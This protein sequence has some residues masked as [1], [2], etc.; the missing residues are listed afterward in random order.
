[1]EGLEQIHS[2]QA[3]ESLVKDTV[4]QENQYLEARAK[5][6]PEPKDKQEGLENG[7]R[8]HHKDINGEGG[9][10]GAVLTLFGN[11]PIPKQLFSSMQNPFRGREH[12]SIKAE[13]PV[14]EISLPNGLTATRVMPVPVDEG[15]RGPTLEE[16]FAPPYSLP[17]LHPPKA[18]KRSSTRD[19]TVTWEF[20]DSVQRNKKGGYTVQS[21]SVAD[22]LSYS[23]VESTGDTF[24]PLEKRMQRD[25]ALSGGNSPV[26]GPTKAAMDDALAKEEEALFRRAYSSFAPSCDN[27]KALVSEELKNMVW[28]QKSGNRRFSEVFAL[29]PALFDES[30]TSLDFPAVDQPDSENDDFSKVIEELDD[31]EN[32]PLDVELVRSKKDVEQ[33]LLEISELLETLASYQRIRNASLPPSTAASRTPI[34]PAP[35]LASQIGKPDDPAEDEMATYHKLRRELA[36]LLLQLPPYAVAKLNGD[37]FSELGVSKLITFAKQDTRGTM[38]E[39]Q[40]ARQARLAAMASASGIASLT[41][42]TSS[43]GQHYNTTAQR[44]PAIGQAA[45]TRYGQLSQFGSRTPIAPPQYQQR[46]SSA[47]QHY[48]TPAARAPGYGQPNHYNRPV[49]AQPSYGQYYQQRPPQQNLA[50]YGSYTPQYHQTPQAQQRPKYYSSQHPSQYQPRFQAGPN[51]AAYQNYAP[52]PP[53]TYN[54]AGS[55]SKPASYAPQMQQPPPM[56]QQHGYPPQPPVSGR[57]TPNNY[58][59]HQQ[60]PVNGYQRSPLPSAV[61]PRP[62]ST[63]PQP[64]PSTPSAA[65]PTP[66]MMQANGHP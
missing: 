57:V 16:A 19:A 26:Q 52:T 35:T 43:A 14:E 13:L 32:L 53:N 50:N 25:R 3:F 65:P 9:R 4:D 17:A 28:W 27:G 29:D 66:T 48:A 31:L 2:I 1:M 24:S 20:K 10:N 34:S 44:T 11:A 61:T 12:P 56:Q 54:H 23:G 5:H 8:S 37:Q 45:N 15:K 47:Q 38:E 39:D 33:C 36:Y 51:T 41:R 30:A 58:L 21:L 7:G 42:P 60:T 46:S 59:T 40:V 55:P 62:V 22:W 63:T 18:H 49:A 64:P 6:S